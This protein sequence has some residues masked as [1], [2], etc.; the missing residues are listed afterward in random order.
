MQFAQALLRR[1]G[2]F[3]QHATQ[4]DR[5]ESRLAQLGAREGARLV[6]GGPF[7]PVPSHREA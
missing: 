2:L 6:R 1:L 7:R 3:S 5:Y 4:D